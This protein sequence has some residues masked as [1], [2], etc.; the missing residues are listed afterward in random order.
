MS[1]QNKS[2]SFFGGHWR[3]RNRYA[4]FL[5]NPARV[6]SVRLSTKI[7]NCPYVAVSTVGSLSR[8]LAP[9]GLSVTTQKIK[10]DWVLNLILK[11][12]LMLL[13]LGIIPDDW[14]MEWSLWSCCCRSY[15]FWSKGFS[16]F[17][18]GPELST[19]IA[20]DYCR[21]TVV[22]W[23]HFQVHAHDWRRCDRID[24]RKRRLPRTFQCKSNNPEGS[25]RHLPAS[26]PCFLFRT[27]CN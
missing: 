5:L 17:V 8:W 3:A 18:A 13:K 11:A 14:K 24:S 4:G 12:S 21:C 15:W 27:W 25:W 19:A 7:N 22:W 10:W 23:H 26:N 6:V 20:V 16:Q 9:L 1:L 2:T